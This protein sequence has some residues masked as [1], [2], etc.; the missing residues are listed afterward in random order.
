MSCGCTESKA[1]LKVI[2]NI[3]CSWIITTP[4]YL[5]SGPKCFFACGGIDGMKKLEAAFKAVY[6]AALRAKPA[7]YEDQL[8][9]DFVAL[10]KRARRKKR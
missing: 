10:A 7:W 4:F 3:N 9:P 2:G 8:L 5:C 1:C 6:A